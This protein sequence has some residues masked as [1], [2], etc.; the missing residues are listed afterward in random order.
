[1]SRSSGL[2]VTAGIFQVVHSLSFIIH[3]VE[4]DTAPDAEASTVLRLRKYSPK[5]LLIWLSELHYSYSSTPVIMTFADLHAL[6]ALIGAA[7]DDIERIYRPQQRSGSRHPSQTSGR[8]TPAGSPAPTGKVK[9]ACS[10]SITDSDADESGDTDISMP[11]TPVSPV[12]T[13]SPSNNNVRFANGNGRVKKGRGRAHT[14]SAASSPPV[15]SSPVTML[16]PILKQPPLDW[17]SLDIPMPVLNSS[18]H[19]A[20]SVAQATPS[21]LY[22]TVPSTPNPSPVTLSQQADQ[23]QIIPPRSP[24]TPH[25]T[26]NNSNGADNE[27]VNPSYTPGATE[28]DANANGENPRQK[29]WKKRCEDLTSHPEVINAMNRIVASCG[30]MSAIV[31]KPFLTMCDAAMGVS[32]L[33]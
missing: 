24:H 3:D 31:Q 1:M 33:P 10:T 17:P 25:M 14:I 23:S 6:H 28:M 13:S 29:E 7:I 30:Q 27:K 32:K 22:L 8:P 9:P 4:E 21:P 16:P 5:E 26:A 12:H 19:E 15:G 11:P 20:I 2:S 18:P